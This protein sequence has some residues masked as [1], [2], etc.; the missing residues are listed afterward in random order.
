MKTYFYDR[1]A[2]RLSSEPV[3]DCFVMLDAYF[4]TIFASEEEIV[5]H[6]NVLLAESLCGRMADVEMYAFLLEDV[7]K[8]KSLERKED[9][10]AAIL[11]RTFWLGFLGASKALLDSCATILAL[12]Y[13]L[14]LERA[15]RTF[16][17][18]DFWHQLVL[19]APAV[20]RRY[21]PLRL[22]LTEVLRWQQET[23]SR[24]PP[25]LVL[26]HHYGRLPPRD[27]LL[28]VIDEKPAE[29]E[30]LAIEPFSAVW[31]DPLQIYTRWRP[32]LL[33]LCEKVCQDIV[34]HTKLR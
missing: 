9:E 33:A 12:T 30:E 7:R 8:R 15:D 28:K 4:D 19:R 14:P 21:H 26:H 29:L 25:A 5:L 22:F 3:P 31:A 11:T 23:V 18:S 20:H 2:Y 1:T 10:R 16:G 17:S 6:R 32:R 24:L 13:Q 27:A 34:E